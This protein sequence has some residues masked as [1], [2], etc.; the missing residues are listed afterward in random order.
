MRRASWAERAAGGLAILGAA[1]AA[2][3]AWG[4][5]SPSTTS[6]GRDAAGPS[7]TPAHTADR[8]ALA[9]PARAA[10]VDHV[11]SRPGHVS[12][13]AFVDRPATVRAAPGPHARRLGRLATRTPDGTDELVLALVRRTA[14]DGRVWVRVRTPLLPAGTVGWVPRS[15]LGAYHRVDTW[16]RVD[17]AALRVRLVRR[18]RTVLTAPIAVGAA[19]TPT[20]GGR[21]Y[22]RD[23]LTQLPPGGVYGPQAFGTSARSERVT[24]WPG[25][26]VVGLHGTNDPNNVPGRVSHGCIRLRNADLARLARLMPVGTPVTIL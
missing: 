10:P 25:G 23:H 4:P 15:A 18:G 20:P 7:P 11:L 17:R 16:L 22:V 5:P 13:Y 9:D 19:A 1:L 6:A 21:F 2:A 8:P 14:G 26:D 12:R 3:L 24:D